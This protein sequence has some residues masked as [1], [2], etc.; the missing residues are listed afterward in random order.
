MPIFEYECTNLDCK[1]H[2]EFFKLHASDRVPKRCPKCR[3]KLERM[4][5]IGRTCVYNRGKNPNW[6]LTET[7]STAESKPSGKEFD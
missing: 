6:P 1:E 4:Y 2:V 5:D 7:D 3:H